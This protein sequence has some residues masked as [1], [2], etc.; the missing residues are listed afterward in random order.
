MWTLELKWPSTEVINC[1]YIMLVRSIEIHLLDFTTFFWLV[2]SDQKLVC[3]RVELDFRP[4][5]AGYL[6]FNPSLLDRHDFQVELTTVVK[7]EQ[8]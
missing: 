4:R 1:L 5:M 2:Y 6:M 7:R 3:P 8:L